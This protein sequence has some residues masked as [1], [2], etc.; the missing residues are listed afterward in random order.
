MGMMLMPAKAGTCHF[1]A[2]AHG[3][4]DPHNWWSLFYHTRFQM[5]YGRGA[6]HADAV[7]H[8]AEE[9]RELYRQ[10]LAER[11]IEWSE[12]DG[13]PVCEKYVESEGT[14]IREAK[15]GPQVIAL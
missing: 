13:E 2:T 10:A 11:G 15:D 12:P 4:D 5:S 9:R 14:T 6:T 1:C 8:L 3:P 7:A